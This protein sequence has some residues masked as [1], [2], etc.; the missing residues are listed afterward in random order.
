MIE[1]LSDALAG[2][3]VAE[4]RAQHEARLKPLG[5]LTMDEEQQGKSRGCKADVQAAGCQAA[6]ERLRQG[7]GKPDSKQP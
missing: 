2:L 3:L 6:P 5:E 7:Q 4:Y 1:S